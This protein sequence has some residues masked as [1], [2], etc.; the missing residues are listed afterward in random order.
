MPINV[1]FACPGPAVAP[2]N[3]SDRAP[4]GPPVGGAAGGKL[5]LIAGGGSLPVRLA[6]AC[7]TMG[8]P[9]HIIALKGVTDPSFERFPHTWC[10]LGTV[11]HTVSVLKDQGC[12]AVCMAGIVRRPNFSDL[13]LDFLGTRLLPRALKAARSGDDALLRFLVEIFEE[14][15]Y[16]VEGPDQVL[17]ALLAPEG[18]MGRL[19][20]DRDAMADLSLAWRVATRLGEFDIAQGAVVARGLVLAVEAAEGTDAMLERCAALPEALRGSQEA[21]AGVL[22][23]RPKP[24]QERRIDLP[25]IGVRTIENAARAGLTGIGVAAGAALV[26]DQDEVIAAA[27]RLGLFVTG[28]RG[29]PQEP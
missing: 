10:G 3:R 23:K 8:R 13:K 12:A 25:T 2:E 18:A 11:G 9:F 6:Q 15:G 7:E 17:G 26:L 28:L 1:L 14:R 5:A 19:Q 16:A 21:R 20:P 4:A 27:D 24:A 29:E 22:V